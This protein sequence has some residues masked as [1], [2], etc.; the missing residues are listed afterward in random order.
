MHNFFYAAE[1]RD[2]NLWPLFAF[3]YYSLND[4]RSL[5]LIGNG[6]K[7]IYAGSE[8]KFTV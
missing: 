6:I 3:L 4:F 8:S 5:Q 1:T 2:I 7:F